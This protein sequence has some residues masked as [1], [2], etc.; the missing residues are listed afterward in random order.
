[1]PMSK[2][3]E[4]E[5]RVLVLEQGKASIDDLVSLLEDVRSALKIFIKIG[6]ACKWLITL[7]ATIAGA[8]YAIK[9]W[10]AA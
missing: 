5:K 4:L 7:G 8:W 3:E 2:I 6:N 9:H 10:L 1:M